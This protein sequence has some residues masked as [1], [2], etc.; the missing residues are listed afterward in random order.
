MYTF[1]SLAIH[2]GDLLAPVIRIPH[3]CAE[4]D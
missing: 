4:V 2:L 3:V 1:G